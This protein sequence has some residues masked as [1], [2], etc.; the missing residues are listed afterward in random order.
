MEAIVILSDSQLAQGLDSEYLGYYEYDDSFVSSQGYKAN[1][2][3]STTPSNGDASVT[4]SE[5]CAVFVANGIHYTLKGHIS[6][7][8]MKQIINSLYTS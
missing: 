2:F 6:T 7:E 3:Q 1:L 4:V 5:K 8:T